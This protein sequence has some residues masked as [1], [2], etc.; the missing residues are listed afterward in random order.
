MI[1]FAVIS[2]TFCICLLWLVRR[3]ERLG[4]DRTLALDIALVVMLAGFIGSRFF[5]IVFE[6]PQVYLDDPY[7]IYRIWEGG[8]VWYGGA[9]A[10]AT[11]GILFVI[12][13]RQALGP[14]L[15]L[16]APIAA[17]GYAMGRIACL[18]VGCCYG[19]VCN[20]TEHIH[21]RY[22]TQAFAIL[23]ESAVVALLL[24]LEKDRAEKRT[25]ARWISD[26]LMQS[27]G[28][29][30]LWLVLHAVGR[31]IMESFRADDRGPAPLGISV[32][33]WISM[34]LLIGALESARR[35]IK[36]SQSL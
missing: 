36:R 28:L 29:F 13:R 27:G 5:H 15:D 6:A 21:F 17:A 18:L 25:R 24:R 11:A 1:Y 14:W 12:F 26:L 23:W 34:L 35:T 2:A 33:T 30:T 9:I 10:G 8:F 4:L 31:I 3:T 32:S 22:P 7:Q 19:A 16:S 20:L